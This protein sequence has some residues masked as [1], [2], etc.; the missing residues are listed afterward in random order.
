MEK[1][2]SLFDPSLTK[3]AIIRGGKRRSAMI[4]TKEEGE[5][6]RKKIEEEI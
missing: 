6:M 2:I 5:V 3:Q 4:L 1:D